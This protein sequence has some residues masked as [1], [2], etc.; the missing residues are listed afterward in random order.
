MLSHPDRVHSAALLEAYLPR[1]SQ[2]AI[3][4]NI[5][6]FMRAME[7]YQA[8]DKLEGA[9]SYMQDICGPSFLSAVD[10]TCPLDVWD[11]VTE[12]ADVTFTVDFPA[13]SNWEFTPSKADELIDKK[14]TMPVLAMMGIDSEAVLPGFRETQRWLMNWLP[15][16]ERA[17]IPYATHGMQIMN[18]VAV[19]EAVYAFFK[20]YPM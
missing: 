11:R 5:A 8:G 14:P 20:K 9:M 19:G 15:Q 10:M 17:A 6:A 4:A 16:A 18:P 1:E 2:E 13:I 7:M 12:S 3:D